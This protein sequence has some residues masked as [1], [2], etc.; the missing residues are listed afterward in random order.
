PERR[1]EMRLAA[2]AAAARHDDGRI[3]AEWGRVERA[4]ARRHHREGPPLAASVDHYRLRS[5]RGRLTATARLSGVPR[6]STA[7]ITLREKGRG[8]LLRRRAPAGS[9]VRW[10]LSAA[11]TKFLGLRHPLVA[12]IMIEHEGTRTEYPLG[13]RSPDTRSLARRI[14]QRVFRFRNVRHG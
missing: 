10:R 13:A 3:V 2:R 4:A 5:R 6:G 8:A 11:D 7:T 12:T 1:A 9:R 14:A